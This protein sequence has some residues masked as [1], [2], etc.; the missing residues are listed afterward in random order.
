MDDDRTR[1]V[2]MVL[3]FFVVVIS[4]VVVLYM[5]GDWMDLKKV[6][7]LEGRALEYHLCVESSS[8]E[9]RGLCLNILTGE[10]E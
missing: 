3:V 10:S 6:R 8:R 4:L 7:S 9:T 2:F 5:V 1:N